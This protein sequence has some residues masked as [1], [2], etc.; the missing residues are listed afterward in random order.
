MS[1]LLL[2]IAAAETG[3]GLKRSYLTRTCG[4]KS[5]RMVSALVVERHL[6]ERLS[7]IDDEAGENVD[8]RFELSPFA[9]PEGLGL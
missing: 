9:A 3:P 2:G 7:P 8:G 5:P 6:V 1:S 4:V